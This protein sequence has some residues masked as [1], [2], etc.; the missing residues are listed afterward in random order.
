SITSG[1]GPTS[2]IYSASVVKWTTT[3]STTRLLQGIK[4]IGVDF[5]IRP[6]I[7]GSNSEVYHT[8][9]SIMGRMSRIEFSTANAA[10]IAEI[11]DGVAINAAAAYF[12]NW[13]ADGV[14]RVPAATTTHVKISG[15][16]GVITPGTMNLT[17]KRAGEAQFIYT[18]R[19][20]TPM[21]TISTTSA[22]PTS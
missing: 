6:L 11:G 17:H 15:T 2:N 22:I 4:Q 20:N 3:G 14:A 7:E 18:P 9:A 12:V 19:F 16:A 1:A 8:H 5:G 13:A 21:L 10:A